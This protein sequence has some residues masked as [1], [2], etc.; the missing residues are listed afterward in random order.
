MEH[1][2]ESFRGADGRVRPGWRVAIAS[3]TGFAVSPSV[4]QF[5]TLGVLTPHLREAFGW[6]VQKVSLW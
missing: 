3:A 4:L 1:A 5:M 2:A 6:S